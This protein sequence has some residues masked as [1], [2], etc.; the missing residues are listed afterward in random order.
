MGL[1]PKSE[2]KKWVGCQGEKDW[3]WGRD[4]V[5]TQVE[6]GSDVGWWEVKGDRKC[7]LDSLRNLEV[8][9]GVRGPKDRA[10]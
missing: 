10:R 3:E 6:L 4:G 2:K 1:G 8:P 7:A 5:T 9:S